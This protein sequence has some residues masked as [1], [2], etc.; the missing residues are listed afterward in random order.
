MM[1]CFHCSPLCVPPLLCALCVEPNASSPTTPTHSMPFS[2]SPSSSPQAFA[3]RILATFLALML[4]MGAAEPVDFTVKLETVMKHN[5][6]DFLWFHPRAAA[7]P[8]G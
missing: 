6:G 1:Y 8:G 5:D 4:S 7:I 2:I 3:L